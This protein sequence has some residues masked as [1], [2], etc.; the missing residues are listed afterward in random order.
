MDGS[1]KLKEIADKQ[2]LL[3]IMRS[4]TQWNFMECVEQN[5]LKLTMQYFEGEMYIQQRNVSNAVN[6]FTRTAIVNFFQGIS[7]N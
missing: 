2:P 5:F 1:A 4:D 3:R 7:S 6:P